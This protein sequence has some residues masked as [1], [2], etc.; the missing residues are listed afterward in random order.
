M[1][2]F[3]FAA[4]AAVLLAGLADVLVV[5]SA[6]VLLVASVGVLL[7]VVDG[8]ASSGFG[9]FTGGSDGSTTR[10]ELLLNPK[11]KEMKNVSITSSAETNMPFAFTVYSPVKLRVSVALS[12][13]VASRL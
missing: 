7:V 2:N 9:G 5:A 10:T 13:W 12:V 1:A 11:A 3:F 8:T 6:G 4:L